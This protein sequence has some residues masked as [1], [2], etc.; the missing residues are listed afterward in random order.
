MSNA[1]K[2]EFGRTKWPDL[3]P[4]L[5]EQSERRKKSEQLL[6]LQVIIVST[7]AKPHHT[8]PKLPL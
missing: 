6:V 8:K 1:G 4:D 3:N 2:H 7:T 5:P